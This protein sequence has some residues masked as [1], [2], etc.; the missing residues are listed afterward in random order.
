ECPRVENVRTST[1]GGGD[2][3][4]G[5]LAF[6]VPAGWTY[7]AGWYSRV[8]TDQDTTTRSF[9]GSTWTSLM[10]VGVAPEDAG[11]TDPRATANQIIEC[12]ITSANFPGLT[13]SEIESN[14]AVTVDGVDGWRVRAHAYTPQAPGGGA[15]FEVVVV[16]TGH[17]EGLS[18]F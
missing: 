18:A 12:H 16:D 7:P 4:G 8:L 3:V 9:P 1:S 5:D 6:P 15:V 13:G 14:E 10:V 11:F 2:V 17:G